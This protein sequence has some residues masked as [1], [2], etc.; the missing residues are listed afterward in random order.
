MGTTSA[1]R[2]R[3]GIGIRIAIVV[4]VMLEAAGLVVAVLVVLAEDGRRTRVPA[5]TL[6]VVLVVV[7]VLREVVLS[8]SRWHATAVVITGRGVV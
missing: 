4:G 5:A 8:L 3:A 1:I 2:I 6:A 7:E